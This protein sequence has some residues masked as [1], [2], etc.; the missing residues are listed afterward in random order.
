[1]LLA[2]LAPRVPVWVRL[3][4]VQLTPALTS[5][6]QPAMWA[7]LPTVAARSTA[8]AAADRLAVKLRSV[9]N[10]DQYRRL[11]AVP[12]GRHGS[13]KAI[14]FPALQCN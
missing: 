2:T 12:G 13:R 6:A 7:H 5:L 1:V 3:V 4:L 14:G 11:T 10:A 9:T 8:P